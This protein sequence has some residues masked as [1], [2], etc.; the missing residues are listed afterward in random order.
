M[1]L[2]LGTIIFGFLIGF[3]LGIRIKNNPE[4]NINFTLG[5]YVV[6]F[7]V[8]LVAAWQLGPFPFYEDINLSS[9]FLFGAIGII[10]GKFII[11]GINL[12]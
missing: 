5:S 10:A 6:I 12:E 2:N 1:F 3:I 11:S 7:I 9:G 4:S 8:S